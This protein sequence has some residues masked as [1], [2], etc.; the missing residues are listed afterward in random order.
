M[1]KIIILAGALL[2][3][4]A[5]L[6][7]G[8]MPALPNDPEVKT[9]KLDNGMT[10][11]IRHNALP[12]G[13]AEFYL[14]TNAGAI[15]E[16]PDQD[17]LAHFLEHMCF[18]GL[19]NL[20]GKQML[21]YLQHIGAEFGRNINASTG[22]E[23][24]QY[25]LNNMPVTREGILDTCLL[26]MH[27]YSHFVLNDPVEIDAERG[28]ILEEKRT[29]NT[30]SWRMFEASAPYLYGPSS[31]YSTCTVIGSADNLKNF[32]PESLKN[33]YETWYRPDMQA[34]IVVGDIDVD[35]VYNK[36]VALFSDIPAP[37]TPTVKV[38]PD[39]E[40]ND[41]PVVGILTDKENTS[42]SVEFYWKLGEPM[43]KEYNNTTVGYGTKLLKRIVSGVMNERFGDISAKADAPFLDA[44]LYIG[45]LCEKCECVVGSVDCENAKVEQA[46][47][48]FL[49]EVEKLRR[50]GITDDEMKRVTDDFLKN[51]KN[52][53]DGASTRKNPEFIYPIMNNF[54][55]N[56][57]YMTPEAELQLATMFCSQLNAAAVNQAIGQLLTGQHLSIIYTGVDQEG[58]VHPTKE[59]LLAIVENVKNADIQANATEQINKDFMAGKTLKSVAVKSVAAAEYEGGIEWT[60]KNGLKV[61][62]LP[63]QYKK[64]QVGFDLVR[65]GGISLVPD[66]DID[67][68]DSNVMQMFNAN[69]GIS[70]FSSTTVTKML[71]GKTVSVNPYM[72]G[73]TSGVSGSCAPE[74]I[75]TALQI[76]NLCFTDPRFDEEEWNVGIN[77]LKAYIP[78][79]LTTPNYV[80]NQHVYKGLFAPNNRAKMI[81]METLEKASLATYQK[82][83]KQL[84]SGVNGATLYVVGNIDPETLKPLVEKY[85]ASLPKGKVSAWNAAVMPE[86]AQGTNIDVFK[87]AMTTPKATVLQFYNNKI[88][89]SLQKQVDLD[90]AN[91]I[92]DMIYVETLRE[93]EGG[94]YGA[95]VRMDMDYQPREEAS[96]QI[97]FDTNVDQQESLRALAIKGLKNL[98]ENG[99][100]AEQLLR[101]CEN[102]KKNIPEKRITNS[103]WMNAMK[104][105]RNRGGDYDKEYEAA[106]ENISAEGIKAVLQEILAPNNFAECVM[107]PAE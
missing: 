27:D 83:Y 70:S 54:F 64:D 82:Y 56:Q 53:V 49:T 105:N 69:S 4:L 67:S 99:P 78:N 52:K 66:E 12:E 77:Q 87:T 100:T 20:P 60:L 84:F 23:H 51:L 65:K 88:G 94:T 34:L 68:F 1:K 92:L 63:T 14:A 48:V 75:E 41:E 26:V 71:S 95:S 17:G 96:I 74:D 24:T 7:Q 16:T 31:K 57:P 11:Y 35:Q 73:I 13:R 18:N 33:F 55:D 103:Y 43:P 81:S 42:T 36:I 5:A 58:N 91:F 50:F 45:N 72:R 25:M 28:V 40:M 101:A 79:M 98:A 76:L 3:S 21:D 10:Y 104:Y 93:E 30:A 90:A 47:T 85:C 39:V 86:Y 19:K 2:F 37:A 38:M 106:V 29:R 8:Q 46:A 107:L 9:G 89:Y 44:A 6:A 97:Y 22:I 62:V 32:K 61:V 15:Q 80:L 102:A 59:S